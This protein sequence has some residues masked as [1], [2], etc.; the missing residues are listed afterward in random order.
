MDE[1]E[2]LVLVDL[3][4]REESKEQQVFLVLGMVGWCTQG[5]E[6]IAVQMSQAPHWYMQG[7]L[8]DHII[9]RMEEQPTTSACLMIQTI[10]ATN[11]VF[12]GTTMCME[13]SIGQWEDHS[14]LFIPTMSP[15]LCAMLQL[16]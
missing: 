12:K 16:G 7:E 3:R 14:Q 1:M 5:G 9:Y 11:L 15:V 8:V 10:S 4:D 13:L 2:C 6:K